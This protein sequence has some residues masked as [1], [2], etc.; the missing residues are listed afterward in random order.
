MFVRVQAGVGKIG[1]E[2]LMEPQH[3]H[4]WVERQQGTKD[5]GG[6]HGGDSFWMSDKVSGSATLTRETPRAAVSH[7]LVLARRSAPLEAVPHDAPPRWV[8]HA[9]VR[10]DNE[11]ISFSSLGRDGQQGRTRSSGRLISR[12]DLWYLS[13]AADRQW[14]WGNAG[15]HEYNLDHFFHRRSL[16]LAR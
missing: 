11:A 5:S 10:L 16:T 3:G 1:T 12:A 8:F 14:C 7:V 4:V 6:G 15:K 9:S 13:L 2:L